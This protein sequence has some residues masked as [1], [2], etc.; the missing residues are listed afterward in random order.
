MV[1]SGSVLAVVGCRQIMA[2]ELN[3]GKNSRS[4][5]ITGRAASDSGGT[6]SDRNTIV[7][8]SELF[9]LILDIGDNCRG[10]LCARGRGGLRSSRSGCVLAEIGSSEVMAETAGICEYS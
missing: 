7:R 9:T 8:S 10:G 6:G 5:R 2:T 1:F 3:S 4:H